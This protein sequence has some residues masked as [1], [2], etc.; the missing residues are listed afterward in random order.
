MDSF[1]NSVS[2]L[3]SLSDH[4]QFITHLCEKTYNEKFKDI[5]LSLDSFHYYCGYEILNFNEIEIFYTYGT[6]NEEFRESF[7]L[8]I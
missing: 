7:K 5:N 8:K 6:Q 2:L 1:S 4:H 3:T